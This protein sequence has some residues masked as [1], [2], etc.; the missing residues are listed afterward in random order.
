MRLKAVMLTLC[1]AEFLFAGQQMSVYVC[2]IGNV[3]E[4]IIANAKAETEA[5]Y[6]WAG[7]GIVWREC[8]EFSTPA[9]QALEPWFV[10]RLRTDKRP[11][12]VGPASLD[13]MGKAFVTDAGAGNM[14]DAY[15]EAIEAFAERY[16]G[17]AGVVLGFVMAHEISHLLLGP[18]HAAGGVMRSAWSRREMQALRQRWLTGRF[19]GSW[20]HHSLPVL[21]VPR[22]PHPDVPGQLRLIEDDHVRANINC[23]TDW[24][25]APQV[26]ERAAPFVAVINRE[27]L[28]GG[29]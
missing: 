5:V 20:L 10:I 12:T 19:R 16:Q 18:G 1:S 8:G 29:V 22:L 6:R 17:D 14:A 23:K 21:V 24:K 11:R 25:R 3:R 27:W 13:V 2:N 9:S 7:V 28:A 4:S 26:L 15:Y